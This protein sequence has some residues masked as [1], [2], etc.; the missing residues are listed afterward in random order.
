[1][2]RILGSIVICRL[3]NNSKQYVIAIGH[4]Q[5]VIEADATY[6]CGS[7]QSASI[8]CEGTNP[9]LLP[10]L[11]APRAGVVLLSSNPKNAIPQALVSSL[12][13]LTQL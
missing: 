11:H 4:S 13:S 9:L 5:G 6:A 7:G 8:T 12:S 2:A 10:Q 3:Q 1:M